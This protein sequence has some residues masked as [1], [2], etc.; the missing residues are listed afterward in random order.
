MSQEQ[1][2]N[3]IIQNI[4]ENIYIDTD[5]EY[6][7]TIV[8]DLKEYFTDQFEEMVDSFR[9]EFEKNLDNFL[10]GFERL[11]E[12]EKEEVIKILPSI[13]IEFEPKEEEEEEKLEIQPLENTDIIEDENELE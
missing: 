11:T 13:Q 4:D 9:K 12:V 5:D 6:Q 7:E 3:I 10:L 2:E 8:D 1:E